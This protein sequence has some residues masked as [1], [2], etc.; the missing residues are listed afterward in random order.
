MRRSLKT[1][2]GKR[3]QHRRRARPQQYIPIEVEIDQRK[4]RKR[5]AMREASYRQDKALAHGRFVRFNP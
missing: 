5:K 1:T 4:Q 2:V 3:L